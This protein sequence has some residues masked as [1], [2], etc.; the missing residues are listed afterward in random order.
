M[1]G[2]WHRIVSTENFGQNVHCRFVSCKTYAKTSMNENNDSV[3]QG[4]LL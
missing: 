4:E 3:Q 1:V 2:F